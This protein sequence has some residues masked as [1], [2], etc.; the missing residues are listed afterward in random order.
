MFPSNGYETRHP[1]TVFPSLPRV[2]SG[3]LPLVHRY[4]EGA[5]SSCHLSRR[6]SLPSFGGTLVAC[7]CFAPSEAACTLKGLEL[8]SGLQPAVHTERLQDLPCSWGT[9]IASLPCSSTPVGPHRSGHCDHVRCDPRIDHGEGT[10]EIQLSRL[11]HTASTLAVYASQLG[12]P[13][14]HARLASGRWP[15]VTGQASPVGFH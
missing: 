11:N 3:V 15:S 13:L 2:A 5:V 7:G 1:L 8:L 12:L 14:C 4:Y 10:H 9:P 6:T